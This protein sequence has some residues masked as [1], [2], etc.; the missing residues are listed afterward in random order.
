MAAPD[1]VRFSLWI[2]YSDSLVIRRQRLLWFFERYIICHYFVPFIYMDIRGYREVS[3][4]RH[5][6][7]LYIWLL[8]YI[9]YL[10]TEILFCHVTWLIAHIDWIWYRVMKCLKADIMCVIIVYLE[11]FLAWIISCL[12]LVTECYCPRKCDVDENVDFYI[13]SRML[14]NEDVFFRFYHP[15]K[16]Y[17]HCVC[18]CQIWSSYA[19]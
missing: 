2:R 3:N 19:T 7:K 5:T 8:N 13:Y 15:R 10:F 16:M 6:S 12:V 11:R 9:D 18:K 14:K 17:F 4:W 1:H